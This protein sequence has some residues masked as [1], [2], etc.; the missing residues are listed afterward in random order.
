MKHLRMIAVSLA[1]A[2]I[3]PAAA[4]ET[5]DAAIRQLME[6]TGVRD[7]AVQMATTMGDGMRP[8]LVQML[9]DVK[10]PEGAADVMIEEI[11]KGLIANIDQY[12]E[13]IVPV[14]ERHFSAADIDALLAFYS[15]EAGARSVAAMP[16]ILTETTALGAAWGQSTTQQLLPQIISRLEAEGVL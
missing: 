2:V 6:L 5:K 14:Y 15:T 3:T 4:Q 8:A 12:I 11:E 7:L 16:Q 10:D 13:Q 1:L 9:A